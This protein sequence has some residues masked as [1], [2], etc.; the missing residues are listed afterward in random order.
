MSIRAT[1]QSG[2]GEPI[3]RALIQLQ[4]VVLG[5]FLLWD[6]LGDG[7]EAREEVE[8]ALLI[9]WAA[10]HDVTFGTAVEALIRTKVNFSENHWAHFIQCRD[11]KAEG[12]A[13]ILMLL[14]RG[15]AEV[16]EQIGSL[17]EKRP[18]KEAK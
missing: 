11:F 1:M 4:Q 16:L 7:Y 13:E 9:D 8:K 17:L 10:K 2:E 12:W 5:M 18:F 3:E 14:P 15:N 6:A